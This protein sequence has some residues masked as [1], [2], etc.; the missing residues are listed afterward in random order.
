MNHAVIVAHPNPDSLTQSAA[1]AYVSATAKLGQVALLRD[2]YAMDFDPRLKAQ[3]I[4]RPAGY[5]FGDDVVKERA[6]LE[7]VDTFAFIYPLW[8]NAP[9][10]ILKGYIDRVFGMGFGFAPGMGGSEPL[11]EGRRLISISFSGAPEE[12]VNDTGAMGALTTLLDH[13]LAAMCGLQVVDHLH[14]GGI[15]PEM[16]AE[17]VEQIL[18][19]VEAR[20]SERFSGFARIQAA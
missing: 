16:D 12:W 1:R 13:H 18:A 10:A 14:F 5:Q 11:L 4:P 17:A 20:V 6:L 7:T 3:E 15:V 9:P 19:G 8:F 2:L